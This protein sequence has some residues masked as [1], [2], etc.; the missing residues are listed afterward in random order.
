MDQN[1]V[2][3][4]AIAALIVGMLLGFLFARSGSNGSREM[5]LSDELDKSQQELARYREEVNTHFSETA[6]LVNGLTAQYQKVHEHLASSAQTLCRDEKLVASLQQSTPKSISQK[7]QESDEAAEA[8]GEPE[9]EA[10][11]SAP[12]DYAPK[13][14]ENEPG[15]LSDKY[16]LKSEESDTTT[17]PNKLY[18]VDK[19]AK[20]A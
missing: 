7:P 11:F 14:A 20:S 5:K 1:T 19:E 9:S 10:S 3:V 15:T 17:D 13:N 18:V 2:W 6:E 12:L 8:S 4:I 16:G